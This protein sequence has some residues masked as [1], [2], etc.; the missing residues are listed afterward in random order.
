MQHWICCTVNGRVKVYFHTTIRVR[1]ELRA[2][3]GFSN[4]NL[5]V[6]HAVCAFL[7]SLQTNNFASAILNLI[8]EKIY[9]ILI[10]PHFVYWIF[11][12]ESNKGLVDFESEYKIHQKVRG[13]GKG[14]I[15][16]RYIE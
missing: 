9:M 10:H 1:S 4:F 15:K 6:H 3:L 11:L 16:V 14:E 5:L 8:V 13:K 12:K 2:S 7:S